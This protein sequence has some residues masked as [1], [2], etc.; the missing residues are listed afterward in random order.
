MLDS[1]L[2]QLCSDLHDD[3]Q[4]LHDLRVAIE[5]GKISEEIALSLR[6][7]DRLLSHSH[8][9]ACSLYLSSNILFIVH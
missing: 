6:D 9:Q 2:E 5:C 3:K 8:C 1:R 7:V 4:N